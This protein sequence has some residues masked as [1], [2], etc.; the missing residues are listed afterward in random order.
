MQANRGRL[1][2]GLGALL[3][4]VAAA[5]AAFFVIRE[6]AGA[7]TGA[8]VFIDGARIEAPFA[9]AASG[10][11][12]QVNG[13]PVLDLLPPS[14][15][16]TE[17]ASTPASG[18]SA[19]AI[20]AQVRQAFVTAGRGDAGTAAALALLRNHP[21]K[22]T[23]RETTSPRAIEVTD[24]AGEQ[25]SFLI[26]V[27]DAAAHQ[28]S[29]ADWS[30]RA[31]EIARAWQALLD[32]GGG[33]ITSKAGTTLQVPPSRASAFVA[34][35]EAARAKSG[36]AKDAALAALLQ[37][38]A[39]VADF[40]GT[41]SPL[42]PVTAREGAPGTSS[43]SL[44]ITWRGAAGGASA[45]AM[46]AAGTAR[47]P[48]RATASVF[49]IS[50]LG[51][52]DSDPFI[53]AV[54]QEGYA[55][56]V[57][58]NPQDGFRAFTSTSGTGALYIVSHSRPGSLT[59]QKFSTT[60]AINAALKALADSGV[61][62]ADVR[63]WTEERGA[64]WLEISEVGIRRYWSGR[65]TIVHSA[66]CDGAGLYTAF[67]A[68][69]FF[70]YESKIVCSVALGDTRE[71][72][73]RMSGVIGDGAFRYAAAAF[74][75]TTYSPTF[76]YH[77]GSP[78]Q[79]TALSPAVVRADIPSLQVGEQGVV[80]IGFDTE[81]STDTPADSVVSILGCLERTGPGQWQF[82]SLIAVP[83][84]AAQRGSATVT[85]SALTAESHARIKL[86]G[87][88]TPGKSGVAPNRD[89]WTGS[90]ECRA[91]GVAVATPTPRT[92]LRTPNVTLLEAKLAV[93]VTT[94]SVTASDP[95]RPDDA[96]ALKY[97]WSM[98]GEVCGTPR[99]PWKQ[100]GATVTWSHN[101]A[102][103]D[104]CQHNSTDHNSITTVVVMGSNGGAVVCTIRGT[105]DQK[106]ANPPCNPR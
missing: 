13:R 22:P 17:L 85:V 53:E 4:A 51:E 52:R 28:V 2:L 5:G 24:A 73:G 96:G 15:A 71:L 21:A 72:W 70:G 91:S 104:L 100:S 38:P 95:D 86:D 19:F 45:E 92:A 44:P 27:P 47:T 76:R 58:R 77:D 11:T 80:L 78:E 63:W 37:A 26:E 69:E 36:G 84:R 3:L 39:L 35:L 60:P 65:E 103:P 9:V 88:T 79:E 68:R 89:D 74:G 25:G 94:F 55:V 34:E 18:D 97:E 31:G 49:I 33:L 98:E 93:P 81:M 40:G 29:A 90:G 43:S 61:K 16:T 57:Y 82:G 12:V 59:L 106:I 1:G 64:Y 30:M 66:S 23:V 83:V 99:A 56:V 87:N 42:Q 20:M 62:R 105:N 75:S 46:Q 6:P 10:T 50:E 32:G 8:F 14:S 102:A 54:Q 101:S 41:P 67:K 48:G 7:P